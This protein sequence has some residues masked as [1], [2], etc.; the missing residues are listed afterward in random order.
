MNKTLGAVMLIVVFLAVLIPFASSN[1][2][3]LEK[4]ATNMG[5]QEQEP[6]WRGIMSDYS[7]GIA[8]SPYASTLLAGV[9]GMLMVL[10]ATF[11]LGKALTS[12]K[13][14]PT[15]SDEADAEQ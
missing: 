8:G 12:K 9:F 4:V 6:I 11:G 5:V 10:L 14:P 1:P 2:D 7:A 13:Q 15:A 3:G